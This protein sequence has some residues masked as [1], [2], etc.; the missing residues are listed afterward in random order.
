MNKNE[1]CLWI[2]GAFMDYGNMSLKELNARF[3][4]YTLNYEG[5]EIQPRTFDRDRRYIAATFQVDIDFDPRLK[6]YHLVNPE[7]IHDNPIFKYLLGSIHVNNLSALALKH[8]DL[9]MLQ[10][11]P[12]GIEWLHILLDAIDKGRTVCFNYTSYYAKDKTF[13]FEVIPCFARMFEHRW[14]L[15]CEYLDRSQTRVFALERMKNLTIGKQVLAPSPDITPEIFY[16]D[17]F[18]I[19]RDDKQ[20]ERIML[21]AY[22]NQVDYIRSLPLHPSQ[23][24]IETGE[25]YAVF[26]YYL[27]PSFDFI[28]QI[29]WHRENVEILQPVSFRQE[30][31]AIIRQ[32]LDRYAQPAPDSSIRAGR[33]R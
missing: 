1:R 16:K 8:K 2:V 31:L 29:L 20:P 26:Q 15:V 9:I 13:S 11:I 4:D 24:E 30:V 19:I 25:D 32:M 33:R 18:G 10:E 21:K 14:Y 5:E 12:T 22:K 3:L 28:Q 23:Q 27:R 7:E 17:C 6:K